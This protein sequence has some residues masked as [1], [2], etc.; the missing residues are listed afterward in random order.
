MSRIVGSLKRSIEYN[1]GH[2][3]S[4]FAKL[5][6]FC[7]FSFFLFLGCSSNAD[8]GQ[9]SSDVTGYIEGEITLSAEIDTLADYSG[10][11]VLVAR[12]SNVSL[13]TL[14]FAQTNYDGQFA[15]DIT[16]PAPDIYSLIIARDGIVLTIDEM[17]VAE[18]DSSYLKMEYPFGNRPIVVRS[19]ENAVLLGFKNTMSL[20]NAEIGRLTRSGETNLQAYGDRIAQT[21]GLLWNLS[22]TN[23]T[24][25]V[26]GLSAVQSIVMLENWNDSLLVSRANTLDKNSQN[27]AAVIGVARRAQ[28]RVAGAASGVALME[29]YQADVTSPENLVVLQSEYVLALRDNGQTE[30][31][32][33]AARKLK[34]EYA[35]DSTWIQWADRAIYDLEKLAPGLPA[36][37]FEA[38][39]VDGVPI[40]LDT[41]KGNHLLIE[42][43]APGRDFERDLVTRNAAYRT[44]GNT[45]EILSFSLQADSLLNAA[46]FDGR[47]M[48]G[49]HVFLPEGGNAPILDDYNVHLVPT[50]FLLDPNGLIVGKYVLGN[51]IA[52]Y[53]AA[54]VL[55]SEE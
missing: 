15:M 24:T 26:A 17:V 25:V 44:G 35:I 48:P 36:P 37:S 12:E 34:M 54:R 5:F 49:R 7:A 19:R 55:S 52:A 3:F 38:I 14:A 23:P 16:V 39:D 41:F 8:A 20:H 29:A 30:D 51:G 13:D 28:V 11:E 46:F 6:S 21:T 33:D 1:N 18:G 32:L 10:F 47:D 4:S 45:F 2:Q 31:A 9:A 22:T 40:N 50:R 43:Y 42:F 27:F 53:E